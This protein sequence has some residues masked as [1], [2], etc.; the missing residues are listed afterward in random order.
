MVIRQ[1]L[2]IMPCLLQTIQEFSF[3]THFYSVLYNVLTLSH[4][5][6]KFSTYCN[7]EMFTLDK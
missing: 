1:E 6:Q 7:I 5:T 4:I 3:H 2:K